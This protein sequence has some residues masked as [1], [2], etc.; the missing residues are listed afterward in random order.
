[1][2][3]RSVHLTIYTLL[4]GLIL[5]SFGYNLIAFSY[6]NQLQQVVGSDNPPVEDE[7]LRKMMEEVKRLS[8]QTYTNRDSGIQY[9][10]KTKEPISRDF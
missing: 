4:V 6:L 2:T 3:Q 10:S 7:E 1:M 5:I 9:D 8:K